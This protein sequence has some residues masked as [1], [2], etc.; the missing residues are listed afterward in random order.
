MSGLTRAATRTRRKR[1]HSMA[2][3]RQVLAEA[4][5]PN[6]SMKSV[7]DKYEIAEGLL[8]AWRSKYARRQSISNIAP[9]GDQDL[10]KRI[11]AGMD[12]IFAGVVP[13]DI[14]GKTA[15]SP[16]G[17]SDNSANP[18]SPIA[19]H[20]RSGIELIVDD[21]FNGVTLRR[22]LAVFGAEL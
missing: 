3:K 16:D 4:A 13:T 1:K 8:Y 9:I 7:A 19:I 6:V 18:C 2:F 15:A 22:L 5:R 14:N 21:N 10:S 20:L 11:N 12:F 17:A